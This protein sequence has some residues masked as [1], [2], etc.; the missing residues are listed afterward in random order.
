MYC[1]AHV[2]CTLYVQENKYSL[3]IKELEYMSTVKT[4]IHAYVGTRGNA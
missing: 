2:L 1:S 4:H 3:M